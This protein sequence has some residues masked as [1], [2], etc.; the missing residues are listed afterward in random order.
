MAPPVHRHYGQHLILWALGAFMVA[1]ALPLP[2]AVS[3][4]LNVAYTLIL[5]GAVVL[6][7]RHVFGGLCETCIARMPLDAQEQAGRRRAV[8]WIAHLFM[9][10][11]RAIALFIIMNVLAE[12][13][14]LDGY[15]PALAMSDSWQLA[16]NETRMAALLVFVAASITHSR[17]RLW[18]PYCDHGDG[19]KDRTP[20]TPPAV[21]VPV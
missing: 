7:V 1:Q 4:T 20:V 3:Q 18:C 16:V 14:Y 12:L 10:K 2:Q 17:Y 15:W 9:T 19:G 11:P 13:P 21:P 5:T 6:I 8:L